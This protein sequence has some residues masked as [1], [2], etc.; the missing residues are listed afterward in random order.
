[1]TRAG[2]A[3]ASTGVTRGAERTTGRPSWPPRSR[4]AALADDARRQDRRYPEPRVSRKR[5]SMLGAL[6]DERP[7]AVR[8]LGRHQ[9][10]GRHAPDGAKFR[11]EKMMEASEQPQDLSSR[12]SFL[13]KGAAVG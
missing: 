8:D 12:R 1:M 6:G 4:P 9:P 13:L 10:A 5:Q 11:E 7:R 3:E 2:P